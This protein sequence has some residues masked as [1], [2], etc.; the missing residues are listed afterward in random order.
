MIQFEGK[1]ANSKDKDGTKNIRLYATKSTAKNKAFEEALNNDNYELIISELL[2]PINENFIL[3]TL[4]NRPQLSDSG[5]D[6]ANTL[7]SKDAI[8]TFIDGIASFDEVVKMVLLENKS[9]IN[10]NSS[11]T[12]N[13]KK[14]TKEQIKSEHPDSYATIVSE[15]VVSE[16]ERVNS[17]LVYS[18]AD[19]E[20]VNA[21]IESGKDISPSQ[22]ESLMVKMQSATMIQNLQS[23]NARPLVT[24]ESS[25]SE[26]DALSDS[27]KEIESAFN[28]KI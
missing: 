28:F 9:K 23:D 27:E 7:F 13:S 6:T 24:A 16:R 19:P 4:A 3:Q 14:M 21:G 5:F 25:V 22:R 11:L 8:G 20:S 15:G 2:D 17:W 18:K 26:K 12:N 10:I 1:V